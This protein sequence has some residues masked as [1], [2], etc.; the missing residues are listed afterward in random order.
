MLNQ[1]ET[2]AGRPH[3]TQ[4]PVV[5]G[6]ASNPQVHTVRIRRETR[7]RPLSQRMQLCVRANR[8]QTATGLRARPTRVGSGS[9]SGA[10]GNSVPN[11]LGP[12]NQPGWFRKNLA[13]LSS[14]SNEPSSSASNV[15]RS[16]EHTSELQ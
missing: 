8:P 2:L 16:E 15:A 10:P 1:Q 14:T 9:A 5:G 7:E 13:V 4:P 6:Q 11:G 12:S 3:L